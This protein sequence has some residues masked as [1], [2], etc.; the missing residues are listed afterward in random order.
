MRIQD[1]MNKTVVTVS[2]EATVAEARELLHAEEIEHLVVTDGKKVVGVLSDRDLQQGRDDS[3]V[4]SV[5]TKNAATISPDETLRK[6][7]GM[8]E[9]RNIG[10]LPV[11]SN[12]KLDGIVST[13]DLL[14][15]LAKG[16]TRPAPPPERVI[17][18]KRGPR[19]RG[20]PI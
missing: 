16:D 9:G 15:A 5:M 3:P 10:C 1:V 20:F 14:R 19:K 7:A 17:L 6:A 11:V 4:K 2:P 8:L 18:R 13:T 12:G